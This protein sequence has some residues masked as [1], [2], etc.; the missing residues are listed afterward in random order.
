MTAVLEEF[1][2][3]KDYTVGEVASRKFQEISELSD[4]VLFQYQEFVD[5]TA[6][7]Y[8]SDYPLAYPALGLSGETGETVERI[9]KICRR[10]PGQAWTAE[11]R[12]YLVLELGDIMWYVSRIANI[13]DADL[14]EIIEKNI[15]KLTNRQKV[16]N[17]VSQ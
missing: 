11:D 9:K 14:E 7:A 5:E 3:Y 16:K 6:A 10:G 1:V 15:D 12:E 8:I 4:N 17:E 13:L 2:V